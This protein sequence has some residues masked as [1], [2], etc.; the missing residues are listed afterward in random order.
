MLYHVAP[1]PDLLYNSGL[2]QPIEPT[3][4]V[5]L[6]REEVSGQ[7]AV[8]YTHSCNT[9]SFLR[10]RGN[11]VPGLFPFFGFD[12]LLAFLAWY[13]LPTPHPPHLLSPPTPRPSPSFLSH[14]NTHPL[15]IISPL[16]SHPR[17]EILDAPNLLA[18]VIR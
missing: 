9:F 14:L 1:M 18:V 2:L 13:H 8:D 17:P 3:P 7:P 5:F 4:L 11:F 16:I 6:L 15:P 10:G 12:S